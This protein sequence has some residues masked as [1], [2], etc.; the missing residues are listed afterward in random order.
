M[1]RFEE[2]TYQDAVDALAARKAERVGDAY[3]VL[4]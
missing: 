1:K 2:F 4:Q 3:D